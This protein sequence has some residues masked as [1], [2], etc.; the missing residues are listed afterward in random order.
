VDGARLLLVVPS[1]R[2]RGRGHKQGHRR[3]HVNARKNFFTM[4]VTES[5]NRLPRLVVQSP[6]LQIFKTHLDISCPAYCW[7][8]LW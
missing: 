2:T 1:D 7:E 4:K 3:F 6:S 8:L 5:W